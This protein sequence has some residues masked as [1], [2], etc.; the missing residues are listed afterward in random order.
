M[1]HVITGGAGG[2]GRAIAATLGADSP[3]LLADVDESG[4]QSAA[5]DLRDHGA[6]DVEYQTVDITDRDAVDELVA[7]A[8]SMGTLE[9]LVHTAGL[10]P[11][12][13]A[14]ERILD[15]N[16][17]GTA[18]LLDA[19]LDLAED[20]TVAIAFASNSGYFVPRDG[21]HTT[22]LRDPLAPDATEKLLRLTG[23]DA[24]SAYAFSKRGVQLLVEERADRWAR[25]GARLLS[26]SPGIIETS[27]ARQEAEVHEQM[28]QMVDR[29]PL[30]RRGEPDE[31][32]SVVE[33]LVGDGASYM[34]GVD[35]LVD[36]GATAAMYDD[37]PSPTVASVGVTAK[38][39]VELRL[40]PLL[41]RLRRA[42][43]G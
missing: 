2:M 17:V 21:P 7:T 31:I 1:V 39:L 34:T 18:R 19:F 32:A 5:S 28:R 37:L 27:M 9:S 29:A 8:A 11:T 24:G 14:P 40:R 3:V 23:D 15:V 43:G 22:L 36:G 38:Y 25:H 4:V 26:L 42:I 12:M 16:L 41:G 10:S 35:V 33:F 6:A 13:G 30:R 20:G